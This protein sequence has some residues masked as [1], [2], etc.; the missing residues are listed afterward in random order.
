LTTARAQHPRHCGGAWLDFNK[1]DKMEQILKEIEEVLNAC[2]Q[3][4]NASLAIA[5][6]HGMKTALTIGINKD[7]GGEVNEKETC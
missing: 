1:G 6:L 7:C 2:E 5:F 4:K 3:E